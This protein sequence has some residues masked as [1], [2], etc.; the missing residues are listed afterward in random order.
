MTPELDLDEC[1]SAVDDG[2]ECQWR[3]VHPRF[4]DGTVVSREAFVGTP[5]ASDE[6]STVRAAVATAEAAY[7]HHCEVL[8][9]EASGTWAITVA[10]ATQANCQIVDDAACDGV[11][12]PGHSFVDMRALSKSARRTARTELAARATARGR[13]H[14]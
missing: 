14:P 10:E 5:G 2:D 1:Q 11:D 7:R 9:L 4:V 13:M 6:I 3:Q 8:G 12:T